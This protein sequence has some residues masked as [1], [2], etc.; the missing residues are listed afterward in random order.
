MMELSKLKGAYKKVED[1]NYAFRTY[2]KSHADLETL[3]RQFYTLH[4]EL[5][6]DYD[7]NACRNCC[8]EY[9]ANFEEHELKSVANYLKITKKEFVD[10]YVNES[11]GEYNMKTTPCTFLKDN[12]ACDIES[13][14]PG[15]CKDYPFTD[16][17]NR[18]FSLASLVGSTSVCPVVFE[19]FEKLKDEYN[20]KRRKRY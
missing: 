14:K 6:N 10:E 11:Y 17:P 4:Q 12:G 1:D 15:S 18:L 5:F 20:F 9:S 8:I 7:C 2:L 16:Q 13:C 3:D 19:M